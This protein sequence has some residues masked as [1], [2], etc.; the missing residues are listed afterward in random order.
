MCRA[1]LAIGRL[2]NVGVSVGDYVVRA[3][4]YVA[5][6]MGVFIDQLNTDY[7]RAYR[8]QVG[9]AEL[10]AFA[11]YQL[12]QIHPFRNANGRTGRLLMN[13]VL[14]SLGQQMIL[15]PKSAG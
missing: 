1:Q 8:G 13:H 14:K 11:H 9:A 15:F 10:A 4:A 6:K 7:R 3:H 12:T 5:A 2:R